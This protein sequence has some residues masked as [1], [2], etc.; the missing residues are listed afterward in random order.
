MKR[1]EGSNRSTLFVLT[2]VTLNSAQ[3]HVRNLA[4]TVIAVRDIAPGEEITISYIEASMPRA[5]RQ[6]R[7]A[8][9]GFRCTCPRCTLPDAEAADSDAR[10]HQIAHLREALDDPDS[11][12]V[13]VDSG[14][15]LVSLYREEG[16]DLYLGGA[17]TRAALNYALFGLHDRAREH[18]ELAIKALETQY[19][20]HAGDIESMRTLA[21]DPRIHWTWGK[22]RSGWKGKG[23]GGGRRWG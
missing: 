1:G 10:I 9:W 14:D 15:R 12:E 20:P 4:L 11:T 19:G 23:A 16:L 18:A 22:R 7:L 2:L 17:H 8:S 21:R 6:E 3:Y 13:D 5:E